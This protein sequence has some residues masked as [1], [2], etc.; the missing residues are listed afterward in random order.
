MPPVAGFPN[1]DTRGR[2]LFSP[3]NPLLGFESPRR[4]AEQF[5]ADQ[6]GLSVTPFSLLEFSAVP[7]SSAPSGWTIQDSDV[8][9]SFPI[10]AGDF[11]AGAVSGKFSLVAGTGTLVVTE[12]S[13]EMGKIRAA[14][15]AAR[16]AIAAS[17]VVAGT[18]LTSVLQSVKSYDG[19]AYAS[20]FVTGSATGKQ[21]EIQVGLDTGTPPGLNAPLTVCCLGSTAALAKAGAGIILLPGGNYVWR[22]GPCYL[23]ELADVFAVSANTYFQ[24]V[25][26]S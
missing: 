22:N 25:Y 5:T 4:Y 16:A 20:T 11:W 17:A 18:A 23:A 12:W 24:T 6:K 14:S 1:V 15:A 3:D 13:Y 26:S 21:V 19:I 10:G 9:Q 2:R 8:R 7:G